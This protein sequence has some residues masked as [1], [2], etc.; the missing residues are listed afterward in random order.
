MFKFKPEFP[1][2]LS[3]K[4][5][6]EKIVDGIKKGL[7]HQVFLGVTGSG[8]TVVMAQVISWLKKPTLIISPN[9][10]LASQTYQEFKEFFPQNA[11]HYFVSYYDYYQPEAYLPLTDTYIEKDAKINKSIEAL[12]HSAVQDLITQR[13][14]IIVASVSC[15]YNLGS[16]E[17]YQNVSLLLKKGQR[18]KIRDFISQLV[19]LGYQ[20]NDFDFS[21][22]SFR[23]RENFI[24]LF[25]SSARKILRVEFFKERIKEIYQ[26]K[27]EF[28]KDFSFSF[29]EAK[30]VS[31]EKV[32]PA[33]FWLTPQAKLQV[34]LMNIE[35]ELRERLEELEK[36]KKFL[37]KERLEKRTRYDLE[38]IRETG[39]CHGIENY[40]RHLEFRKPGSL[41]YTLLDYFPEDFLV[42]IDESHQTIGQLKAM[43]HQ[44]RQRKETL[45]EYGFRLPSA[46]DN[47]PL[48]YEEFEA[49]VK[50]I[51]YV[52][53]TPDDFEIKKA[54]G[55][56]IELLVRPTGL[57][58]PEIEIRKPDNQLAEIIF[59]VKKR[60]EKNQ[61]ALV[62]T[63]TKRLAEAISEKL[64]EE[65]LSTAFL[66]AE[67]KTL[68]RPE[69]LKKLREG[70]IDLLVGVNLLRE[71]LDLPE[72]SLILILDAD[73]EGFLRSKTTL[74]QI[75]GRAARNLDGKVIFFANKITTA[76]REAIK[77]A[78][79]RRAFQLA[80]NK[81]HKIIPR[82]IQ[83]PI[84][85]WLFAKKEPLDL[86]F[87]ND[88]N[89]LKKEMKK[90]VR[91]LD[92]ER[93]AKIRDMIKSLLK[94]KEV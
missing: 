79:R 53:A 26:I 33:H 75:M 51:V 6:A 57:L 23:Q 44:D 16:P 54:K 25:F 5:A 12:R 39:Y 62:L 50:N 77:E 66:H 81:K 71:G 55:K 31:K 30:K 17:D 67:I 58:E 35:T 89:I 29:K 56:V 84:R 15:I 24:D 9:K 76:M 4:R 59:E 47:R 73:K 42:F 74:L 85:P 49:K 10:T 63:L 60:K 1:L 3:Q 80:F 45:I 11:V 88:I 61:R 70:E 64:K 87:I 37:E 43:A 13:D 28:K 8:K 34:A 18:I 86:E 2:T 72:V 32:L 52:S 46:L 40:S 83:K 7:K 41:P 93:A 20:K 38:M 14:T 94:K 19:F 90:S 22:G 92:F 21:P 69:F 65:N 68:E 27:K 82:M 36:K 91:E 48:K 78:K